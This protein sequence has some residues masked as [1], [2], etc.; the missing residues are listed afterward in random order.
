[1]AQH[2]KLKNSLNEVEL[3]LADLLRAGVLEHGRN[4]SAQKALRLMQIGI[5]TRNFTKIERGVNMLVR[6]LLDGNRNNQ[7][8][9]KS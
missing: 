2:K 1:M 4:E 7:K 5:G 9:R 8:G 6:V 3:V